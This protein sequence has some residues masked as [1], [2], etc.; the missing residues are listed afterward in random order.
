MTRGLT[1]SLRL[2]PADVGALGWLMD[3]E[4][5]RLEAYVRRCPGDGN[6]PE[7]LASARDRRARL[8]AAWAR[9]MDRI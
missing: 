8:E 2:T 6:G 1:V 9:R 4:I 7:L 3:R 5:E